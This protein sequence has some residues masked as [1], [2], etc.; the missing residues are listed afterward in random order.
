MNKRE[1]FLKCNII[2]VIDVASQ[3][4]NVLSDKNIT[5]RNL[6]KLYTILKESK[7]ENE[8]IKNLIKDEEIINYMTYYLEEFMLESDMICRELICV[9]F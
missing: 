7:K 3:K 8:P 5:L 6:E 2:E 9:D 1:I 4:S